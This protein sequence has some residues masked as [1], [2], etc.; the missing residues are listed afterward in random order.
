MHQEEHLPA[1]RA[2][3]QDPFARTEDSPAAAALEALAF[4]L[5]ETGKQLDPGKRSRRRRLWHVGPLILCRRTAGSSSPSAGSLCGCPSLIL[6]GGLQTSTQ[7]RACPHHPDHP[8][9]LLA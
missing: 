9:A 5:V 7:L 2:A 3:L 4:S 8:G 1:I 6:I